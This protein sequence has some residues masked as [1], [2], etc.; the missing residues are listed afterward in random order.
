MRKALIF[1]LDGTLWD[2]TL[3]VTEAWNIVGKTYF[4]PGYSLSHALV[5]SLMGKTMSEIATVLLPK[6]AD[7]DVAQSF[8]SDCFAFENEYLFSHPGTLYPSEIES[9]RALSTVYDL[10]IVSNCQAG[11]IENYLKIVPNG[12]FSGHMCWSDTKDEK[13]VTIRALMTSRHIVEALYVGDTE[14]DELASHKARIPFIHASY[15]FGTAL[16][17]E[18]S[19]H[20]LIELEHEARRVFDEMDH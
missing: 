8:V 16:S 10:Y 19:I 4:G 7:P 17:P 6:D 3:Q 1:D 13:A 9:L 15:G 14:K 2:S 20:S 11:Y 18:G 12:L 5:C